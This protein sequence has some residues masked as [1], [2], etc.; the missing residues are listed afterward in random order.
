MHLS[1][2]GIVKYGS[3][4]G[5]GQLLFTDRSLFVLRPVEDWSGIR[6][7][8]FGGLIGGLIWHYMKSRRPI[9]APE[10]LA[11]SELGQLDDKLRKQLLK[12]TFVT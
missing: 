3:K 4:S 11:D 9:T 1:V 8:A 10:H 2:H 5:P 7:H 6:A 12:T